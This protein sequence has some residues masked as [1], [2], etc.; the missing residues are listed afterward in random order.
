MFAKLRRLGPELR[1]VLLTPAL[2]E[3]SLAGQG[4]VRIGRGIDSDALMNML[5][6]GVTRCDDGGAFEGGRIS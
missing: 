2:R 6:G 1:A 5:R 3:D 4:S